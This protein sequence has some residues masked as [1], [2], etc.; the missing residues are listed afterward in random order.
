MEKRIYELE[1]PAPEFSAARNEGPSLIIALD[2][3]ADAGSA[4]SDSAEH[5]LAALE[6]HLV[7][8]FN[9]DELLDY[10]SRRPTV[11]VDNNSVAHIDDFML[12]LHVLKD[13]KN[14][15]FLLLSG[16]EPDL[17]WEAFS[18]VIADLVEQFNVSRTLCLYAVPMTV[19]H[20]RPLVLSAHGNSQELLAEHYTLD[21]RLEVPGS[22]SLFIE[23]ALADSGRK[24]G[25]Y[26]AHIPHYVAASDYPEATFT[27]LQEAANTLDL[28]LPLGSLKEDI[29]KVFAMIQ[30]Q[31]QSHP[32][33]L[34]IVEHL[35]HQYDESMARYREKIE[36][37]RG[38][39]SL[40]GNEILDAE[41]LGA[42]FER[43]LQDI[44][45]DK[46]E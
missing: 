32:E 12:A 45:D 21:T 28:E 22:A 35:E 44:E 16:P 10:R 8:S 30:E 26:T 42:E 13:T 24:V 43:F 23:K 9:S 6:H 31:V 14:K 5:L 46:S 20:T 4:V 3:F 34:S 1:F 38:R 37:E 19:P 25:G 17:R 39:A 15:S 7:A 27:L 29:P 33:M 11:T 36:S 41:K 2:G 18:E 40:L